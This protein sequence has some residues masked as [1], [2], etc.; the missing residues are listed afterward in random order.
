MFVATID[1]LLAGNKLVEP[2]YQMEKAGKF[3]TARTRCPRP[4]VARSSRATARRRRPTRR[5]L[6]NRVEERQVPTPICGASLAQKSGKATAAR[7]GPPGPEPRGT[8]ARRR[9]RRKRKSPRIEPGA[10][11]L[12]PWRR[13][14]L[15]WRVPLLGCGDSRR[16]LPWPRSAINI[17]GCCSSAGLMGRYSAAHE[18]NL[19][20]RTV[21][22]SLDL[23]GG[24]TTFSAFSWQTVEQLQK[25]N[26]RWPSP[27]SHLGRRLRARDVPW[28]SPR[29]HES[30]E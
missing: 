20:E 14:R 5:D 6:G 15:P 22:G 26:V 25:G 1:Y 4:R 24:F 16:R 13:A 21:F 18:D 8:P 30:A 7:K 29:A 19:R 9:K 3:A 28:W 2:L 23:V 27:T 11:C 12:V 17:A 10:L